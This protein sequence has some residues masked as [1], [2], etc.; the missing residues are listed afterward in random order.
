MARINRRRHFRFDVP[1][2]E[3]LYVGIRCGAE[4]VRARIINLSASGMQ[5]G[6]E[7]EGVVKSD[8]VLVLGVD[9][10]NDRMLHVHAEVM[11]SSGSRHGISF[12][13]GPGGRQDDN[14]KELIWVFISTDCLCDEDEDEDEDE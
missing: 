7:R 12:C 11:W 5:L 8:Q 3:R 6:I 13:D 1:G 2:D 4:Y 10:G 9:L 14:I